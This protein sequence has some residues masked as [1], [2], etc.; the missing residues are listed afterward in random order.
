MSLVNVGP[1]PDIP[2]EHALNNDNVFDPPKGIKSVGPRDS[3]KTRS[4]S[5]MIF[6]WMSSEAGRLTTKS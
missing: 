4:M 5:L 2:A 6:T 3:R 1:K